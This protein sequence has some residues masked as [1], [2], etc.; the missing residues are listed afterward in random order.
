M[1]DASPARPTR[2]QFVL[3]A[4]SPLR[5]LVVASIAA[6]LGAALV[7]LWRSASWP[8]AVAVLG[9]V[10]LALAVALVLAVVRAQLRLRQTVRLDETGVTVGKGRRTS[11]AAWAE[12]TSVTVTGARLTLVRREG[13]TPVEVLNPGG[14]Y[15]TAFAALMEALQRF[16]DEDRGYR[17][18]D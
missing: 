13:G 4:P 12:I 5:A 18:L 2:Q 17:P 16:L 8:L 9:L 6:V 10:L 7:V 11:S 3:R 15:E 14:P 1:S